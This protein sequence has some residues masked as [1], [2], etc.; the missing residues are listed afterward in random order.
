[1]LDVRRLLTS[2]LFAKGRSRRGDWPLIAPRPPL[3]L[4]RFPS[5]NVLGKDGLWHWS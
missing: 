1:M 5:E 4:P 3:A 2:D